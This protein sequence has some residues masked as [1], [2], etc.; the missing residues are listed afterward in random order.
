[1][2]IHGYTKPIKLFQVR[3]TRTN[4]LPKYTYQ[5]LS[6]DTAIGAC[7]PNDVIELS[8]TKRT[9][10]PNNFGKLTEGAT[11]YF[12]KSA[13]FP[14]YKLEGSGFKRCIKKEKADFIIVGKTDTK[15]YYRSWFYVYEDPNYMYVAYYAT[16][17]T[18]NQK[19]FREA[20]LTN[21]KLV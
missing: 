4:S 19:A 16:D 9:F 13:T 11:L 15:G 17:D 7:T 1:M 10:N 8:G 21:M 12:D 18:T 2:R 20:G 6:P 3:Y 14:R 5:E